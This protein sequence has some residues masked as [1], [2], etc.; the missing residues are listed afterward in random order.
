MCDN[1]SPDSVHHATA[2][3]PRSCGDRWAPCFAVVGPGP[4][5]FEVQQTCK[6]LVKFLVRRDQSARRQLDVL[7]QLR[8][9]CWHS[10]G[11]FGIVYL[12]AMIWR[13]GRSSVILDLEVGSSSTDVTGGTDH[14]CWTRANPEAVVSTLGFRIR[15]WTTRHVSSC[16]VLPCHV[17]MFPLRDTKNCAQVNLKPCLCS[18]AVKALLI[19]PN[20][21][22]DDN[23]QWAALTLSASAFPS[24]WS[25]QFCPMSH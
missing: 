10:G 7:Y 2:P 13:V 5:H 4:F 21:S 18:V 1:N 12:R 3:F 24:K 8:T 23:A 6:H 14:A 25:H 17:R 22:Q 11:S 20:D 19:H 9:R 16:Y 15:F